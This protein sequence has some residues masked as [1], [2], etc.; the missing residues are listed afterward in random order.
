MF[1]FSL[2]CLPEILLLIKILNSINKGVTK[3]LADDREKD[4]RIFFAFQ[5][6]RDV[7]IQVERL[8]VGDYLLD[9]L[10]VER[11]SFVDFCKSIKDGRLFHQAAQLARSRIQ[12]LIIIEGIS[13]D[14]KGASIKR[15]A[16]QG[17]LITLSLIYG[18]PILRSKSPEETGKLILFAARQIQNSGLNFQCFRRPPPNKN[19]LH[20][21]LKMQVHILQGFPQIG[22]S[23]A[24]Q[25]LEK[26]GT[27][28]KVLNASEELLLEVPGFG[29][30]LIRQIL[31]LSH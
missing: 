8:Q 19:S 22:P 6:Q 4:E 2:K 11:K 16:F 29:R 26:F 14:L 30:K 17:A 31:D 24:L 23:R 1:F 3:I 5:T 10:L 12:P 21:K 15:E 7:I 27:I 25:L 9:N 28:N 20:K 13:A 18:I